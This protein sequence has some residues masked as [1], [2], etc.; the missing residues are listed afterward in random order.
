MR[1]F[2]STQPSFACRAGIFFYGEDEMLSIVL[3]AGKG[4][5]M[6]SGHP[7]VVF[8]VC[9]RPMILRCIENLK[10]M[11][12][13]HLAVVI[14]HGAGEVRTALEAH[15]DIT[16][17]TQKE[18]M[19]T[20][21]AVQ[22]VDLDR[23]DDEYAV[24]I[25]GDVPLLD[26]EKVEAIF[27]EAVTSRLDALVLTTQ[28]HNPRGYG[29]I[30]TRG[31]HFH[32][33]VEEKDAS[34]EQKAVNR[35]NT[36]VYLIRRQLLRDYLPRLSADNNQKEYY[37][38]DIFHDLAQEGFHIEIRDYF[39]AEECMGVNSRVQLQ[40][41]NRIYQ[42]RILEKLMENGV[43]VN[44][45]ESVVL[46]GDLDCEPDSTILGPVVFKGEVTLKKGAV[47]GPF[48][49]FEDCTLSPGDE[50]AFMKRIKKNVDPIF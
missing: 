23:F 34:P 7:K 32:R 17:F 42:K 11:K 26:P 12:I 6:K 29:R 36:G 3:A 18:Q 14:G 47:A 49:Y 5:R 22:Q 21:H 15:G 41:A 44:H 10:K 20:G 48:A 4:T 37:L 38:T 39:P 19:G 46:E 13:T 8:P 2:E 40:E 30:I 9:G 31:E 35:I 25:P 33:I 16:Y 24:I 50:G 1:W 27:N 43:T 45:P 28:L